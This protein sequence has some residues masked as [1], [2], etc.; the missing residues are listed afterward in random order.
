MRASTIVTAVA[1][2]APVLAQRPTNTSICDYYTPALLGNN[3][4]A[5]QYTVLTLIVNTAVI[6]NYSTVNVGVSVPGILAKG[7]Y[8]GTEVNLLP[9]FTG[10]LASS[11]R[12]GSSGVSINFLDDGGAV[13]LT[14][15][16]PANGTS[17]NQ[18]KL[19]T[20]L[21]QYFGALLGCSAAGFPAYEGFGSQAA[22]HRFMDLDAAEVGYF[23]E[24]VG[25]SAASFGVAQADI[26][27]VAT[28]LDSIFN[29]RCAPPTTVIP[30]QGAQLQSI[31]QA[32]DCPLSPNATCAAYPTDVL[33]SVANSTLAGVSNAT[34]L[35]N[36]TSTSS[37]T[38]S[39][40]TGAAV[41]TGAGIGAA[42]LALVAFAL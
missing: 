34:A 17:S 1:A 8:N 23:I 11:N 14:M 3:S 4:A 9:Y 22:V 32:P 7:T 10:G 33:P 12:G 2:A 37:S 41:K 16:M 28:A 27:V 36:S 6:G 13:P 25:L 42:L 38:P 19:L 40:F 30:S 35:S 24:Q 39:T 18:Y 31:C 29:V 20:H 15:N 21:Y 5:N 26:Q